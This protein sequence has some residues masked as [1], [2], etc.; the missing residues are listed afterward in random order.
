MRINICYDFLFISED[1]VMLCLVTM[2]L[3]IFSESKW[4]K[5][6]VMLFQFNH[7]VLDIV[8]SWLEKISIVSGDSVFESIYQPSHKT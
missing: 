8:S 1:T 7:E 6:W 3:R 4:L 2:A 5:N